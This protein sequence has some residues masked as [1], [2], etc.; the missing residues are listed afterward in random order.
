MLFRDTRSGAVLQHSLRAAVASSPLTALC[1]LPASW[2]DRTFAEYA[3]MATSSSPRFLLL[4]KRRASQRRA[5][6][7]RHSLRILGM[8]TLSR[9]WGNDR[10]VSATRLSTHACLTFSS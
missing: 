1:A 5:L 6:P 4:S 2:G 8:S 7:T 3:H 9:S 10:P